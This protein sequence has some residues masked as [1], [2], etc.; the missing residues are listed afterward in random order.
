MFN[1]TPVGL[2]VDMCIAMAL[3][4]MLWKEWL[5]QEQSMKKYY[6]TVATLV[7]F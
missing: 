7:E 3:F 4:R 1:I 6:D 2:I 5:I